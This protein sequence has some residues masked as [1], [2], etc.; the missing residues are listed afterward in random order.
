MDAI[1]TLQNQFLIAMPS[2]NDPFFKRSVVYL[3]EHNEDGAMGLVINVPVDLSVESL[4]QQVELHENSE[5]IRED[6]NRPVYQGGPVAQERGF[7]LHS[8]MKGF[9]SSLKVSDELMVTTSKD[10]LDT[11]GTD[12][13]PH[14]YI[15]TLGYASW[16]A[17]QLEQEIADNSW[18]TLPASTEIIFDTPS[19]KR[20]EAAAKSLGIDIWQLSSEV[21]HA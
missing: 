16:E 4:L 7:V 8:P 19:H 13:Q 18:L 1:N 9:N 10:V 15:V 2:L 20:W 12:A 17:G 21:G 11:L 6:L 5:M 14:D 3:C